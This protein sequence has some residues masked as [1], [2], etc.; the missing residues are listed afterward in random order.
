MWAGP[1]SFDITNFAEWIKEIKKLKLTGVPLLRTVLALS[2]FASY[3][4]PGPGAI[5]IGYL[6]L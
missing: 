6:F 1:V 3:S 5:K 4:S 2:F